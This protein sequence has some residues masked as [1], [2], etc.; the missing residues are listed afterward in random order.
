[1]RN[2]KEHSQIFPFFLT[3][4]YRSKGRKIK[5]LSTNHEVGASAFSFHERGQFRA[6]KERM[7]PIRHSFPV[8]SFKIHPEI[9]S[10]WGS[11]NG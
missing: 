8:P 1:M 7:F 2:F 9:P 6:G 3:V 5:H 10:N 4:R 11:E